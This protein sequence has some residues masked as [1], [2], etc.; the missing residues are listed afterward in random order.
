MKRLKKVGILSLVVMIM[1]QVLVMPVSAAVTI[2][3]TS[4]DRGQFISVLCGTD[5]YVLTYKRGNT[6]NQEC[7]FTGI[8]Y[9]KAEDESATSTNEKITTLEKLRDTAS[10]SEEVETGVEYVFNY[11]AYKNQSKSQQKK[12]IKSFV[13]D[14]RTSGMS[15]DG[16]QKLYV[17]LES[18]DDSIM[19]VYITNLLTEATTA[20]MATATTIL[21]PVLVWFKVLTGILTIVIFLG[22]SV[23]ST[24]DLA[25]LT[26]DVMHWGVNKAFK[27]D[28]RP[29]IVS[30]TAYNAYKAQE[31]G[32]VTLG[33]WKY[34]KDRIIVLL[35]LVGC[36]TYLLLGRLGE[37]FSA[38]SDILFAAF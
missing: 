12:L 38:I 31:S 6:E 10:T 32:E 7:L 35:V 24:I 30:Q 25:W 14:I 29:P 19:N 1:L 36:V 21:S 9:K 13:E 8:V 11:A 17:C 34:L 16:L 20:D 15:R 4:H 28:G 37:A 26:I 2:N 18:Y 3:F 27:T 22:F 5:D 23:S 33:L